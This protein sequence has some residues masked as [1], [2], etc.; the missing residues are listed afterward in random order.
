MHAAAARMHEAPVV[1][2]ERLERE[3]RARIQR[4]CGHLPRDEFDRLVRRVAMTALRFE[5]SPESFAEADRAITAEAAAGDPKGALTTPARRRIV[6]AATSNG[7]MN[8]ADAGSPAPN[9]PPP[10]REPFAVALHAA[11][12]EPGNVAALR[13]AVCGYV[14]AARARGEPVERVIIDLKREMRAAGLVDR[15]VRPDERAVAESVIR[16]CIERYYGSAPRGA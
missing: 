7:T 5:V 13:D 6:E 4:V 12:R 16:W 8:E 10:G 11:F 15:Y 9:V 2:L 3:V 1:R 14:D